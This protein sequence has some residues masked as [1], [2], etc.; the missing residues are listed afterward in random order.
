MYSWWRTALSSH[1]RSKPGSAS[2]MDHAF[3]GLSFLGGSRQRVLVRCPW[4]QCAAL[5]AAAGS[6]R[7]PLVTDGSEVD[8]SEPFF[9]VN[10]SGNDTLWLSFVKLHINI[11]IIVI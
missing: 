11:I 5:D 8:C 2:W 3:S 6:L 1:Q 10:R 7:Y 4:L 9:S